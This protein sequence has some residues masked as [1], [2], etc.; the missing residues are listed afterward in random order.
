MITF[1]N[2]LVWQC[3]AQPVLTNGKHPDTIN[4]TVTQMNIISHKLFSLGSS[5]APKKIQM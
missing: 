3:S 2:W 1:A 4:E 5:I